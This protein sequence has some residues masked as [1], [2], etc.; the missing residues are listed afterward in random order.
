MSLNKI[1]VEIT[2]E[3]EAQVI[4]HVKDGRALL[5]FLVGLSK[6]EKRRLSKLGSSYVD[7]VDRARVHAQKFPAY[8][9][10]RVTFEMFLRDINSCNS[11]QRISAEV[12]SLARDLED[13]ILLMKSEYYQTARLY[14]KAVK[15]AAA[16]GDKDAERIANDL[17]EHYMRRTSDSNEPDDTPDT[18]DTPEQP[19]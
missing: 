2:Q 4:Q 10:Q 3:N 17:S 5:D 15:D 11:L 8:L 19:A 18:P 1:D 7:F 6:K 16:E 12:K 14:Y 13:T 9:P